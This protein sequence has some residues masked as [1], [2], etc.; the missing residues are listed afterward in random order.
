MRCTHNNTVLADLNV[1]S[2]GCSLY[3]ASRTYV[4][5]ITNLHRVVV[6]VSAICLVWRSDGVVGLSD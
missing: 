2:D 3:H 1:V 5:M 4:D 6:E